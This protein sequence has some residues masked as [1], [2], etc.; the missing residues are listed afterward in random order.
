MKNDKEFF[1]DIFLST[2]NIEAY[3]IY[4]GLIKEEKK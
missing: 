4:K 3:L 2:G 1:K